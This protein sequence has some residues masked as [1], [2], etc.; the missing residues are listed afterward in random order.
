MVA[1]YLKVVFWPGSGWD[2]DCKWPWVSHL[3]SF[4]GQWGHKLEHKRLSGRVLVSR[5]M[6][7]ERRPFDAGKWA[8]H[9]GHLF[10]VP[11]VSVSLPLPLFTHKQ[12]GTKT[13][14]ALVNMLLS[15]RLTGAW[16]RKKDAYAVDFAWWLFAVCLNQGCAKFW[17]EELAPFSSWEW[18]WIELEWQEEEFSYSYSTKCHLAICLS[19]YSSLSVLQ[20]P[21][22]FKKKKSIFFC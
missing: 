12:T 20:P 11:G 18:V 5:Q 10:G 6:R 21:T 9:L 8:L 14:V 17:I 7:S 19:V 22:L 3:S 4:S 1:S 13:G 2:S 16:E 15:H